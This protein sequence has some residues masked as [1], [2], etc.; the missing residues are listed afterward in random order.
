MLTLILETSSEKSLI[1]LADGEQVLGFTPPKGGPSLS[2]NLAQEVKNL[3]NGRIPACI[4]AGM[5]PGS[6]TGVRVGAALAQSLA[7]AWKIPLVGFQSP[8]NPDP[9]KLVSLEKITPFKLI[10]LEQNLKT[11]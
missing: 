6:F 7:Y 9:E 5:G 8:V 1:V 11:V 4:A 10:Y 2:K 3:L